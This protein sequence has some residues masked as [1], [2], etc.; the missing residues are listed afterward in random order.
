MQGAAECRDGDPR[1]PGIKPGRYDTGCSRDI[2]MAS[3]RVR[4]L[5]IPMFDHCPSHTVAY[6]ALVV[7]QHHVIAPI[8][9]A[10]HR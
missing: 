8:M 4:P 10:S 5:V 1:H 7:Q 6:R 3:L 9:V 2:Q